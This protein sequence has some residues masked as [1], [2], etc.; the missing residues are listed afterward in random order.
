M[1]LEQID[2]LTGNEM[3][4]LLFILNDLFPIPDVL[5]KRDFVCSIKH[6]SIMERL[7]KTE[8]VLDDPKKQTLPEYDEV[9]QTF[10]SMRLKIYEKY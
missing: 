4:M 1:R 6:E 7:E 5:V 10:E 3:E 9:R 8:E 2:S